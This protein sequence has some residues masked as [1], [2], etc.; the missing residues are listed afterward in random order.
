MSIQSWPNSK[1][2]T[3]AR[4]RSSSSRLHSL[5]RL[6]L[7]DLCPQ[8]ILN[9]AQIVA[10][11]LQHA[12][13]LLE[14]L[15]QLLDLALVELLAVAR[16]LLNVEAGADVDDDVLVAGQ[17]AGHVEGRGEGDEQRRVGL[18]RG[19]ACVDGADAVCEFRLRGAQRLVRGV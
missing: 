3:S 18:Q 15:A 19:Y 11:A 8:H 16:R 6:L 7:A 12:L 10:L 1:S 13:E 5:L 17:L 4:S 2:P 9:H 14:A